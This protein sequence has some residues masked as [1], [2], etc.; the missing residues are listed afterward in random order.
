MDSHSTDRTR[1]REEAGFTLI[2]L[3]VVII[4]IGVLAAIVLPAFLN[5]T[6]KGRD[7]NAKSDARNL[8]SQVE[9]CYVTNRDYRACDTSAELGPIGLDFGAG[10]GQVR[11]VGATD[12][13]FEVVA[14]STANHTFRIVRDTGGPTHRC[15]PSGEGGCQAGG[16]W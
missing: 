3:L 5:Q 1:L 9:S 11:V 10:P 7:A 4:V 15:F 14:I 2:E 8:V 6:D 12:R 13:T 16:V